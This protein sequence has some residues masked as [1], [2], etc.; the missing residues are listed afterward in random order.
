MSLG[1]QLANL[2]GIHLEG[3]EPFH[4]LYEKTEKKLEG[5]DPLVKLVLVGVIAVAVYMIIQPS[6]T[7]RLLAALYFVLP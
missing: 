1:G 4:T 2:S 7:K 6:R 3:M 5:S